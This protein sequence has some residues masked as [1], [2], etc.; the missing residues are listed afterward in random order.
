MLILDRRVNQ[1]VL[2]HTTDGLI[3]VRLCEISGPGRVRL[4]IE[5]PREC[6][7]LRGE[8]T[9]RPAPETKG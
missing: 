8:V 1:D 6:L 4:G 7:I 5:A 2:I 9:P 3:T